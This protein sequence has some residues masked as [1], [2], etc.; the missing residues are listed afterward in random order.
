MITNL[1]KIK[2][3]KMISSSITIKQPNEKIWAALT[4][5]DAMKLWYFDIP[6]FVLEAGATFNF[7]EPGGANKYQHRCTIVEI[8]PGKKLSHTW[9]HPSLSK[10][11]STVTWLLE[12]AGEG[13]T[14]VTVQHEGLESFADAGP[15]F[16]PENYKM[17]WDGLV[18]M[19]KNYVNGLQ[20]KKY[21]VF[22]H[23]PA[24]KVW[25][26]M[27]GQEGYGKWT[28]VF[29]IGSIYKGELQQG[30]KIQ[31]LGPDGSGMYSNI[32]YYKPHT[33]LFFQHIGEMKNFEEMPVDEKAE[34]WTGSFENYTYTEKDGGTQV[35][36]E[37]DLSP[38][39]VEMFDSIFPKGLQILKQ[40]VENKS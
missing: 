28:S 29:C 19:L 38:Q 14:N 18:L 36:A 22:I 9:Q 31:F 2:I 15:D 6:D 25:E 13:K 27:W 10:G 3:K 35:V 4:Q 12:P 40:N 1:A 16:A 7:Y 24:L 39:H 23:A 20:K 33:H 17:G 11:T 37:V 8:V 34:T 26:N 5:K 30:G 32:V 21:E